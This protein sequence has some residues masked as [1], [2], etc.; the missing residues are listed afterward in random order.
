[1]P[2]SKPRPSE[3]AG[4]AKRV[5]HP[6]IAQRMPEDPAYSVVYQDCSILRIPA[7]QS[8]RCRLRVA[9]EDADPVDVA[10]GWKQ[11]LSEDPRHAS[12]AHEVAVI[13]MANE[14]RAGGDWESGIIAPEECFARRSNLV[15][16]LKNIWMYSAGRMEPASYPI[17]ARGGVYSPS[18]GQ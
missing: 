8:N 15:P 6:Y 4:E 17:P 11:S 18:V 12:A 3:V 16:R 2:V 10:I 9:I 13:N 7:Q 14:K 1:M 5:Y